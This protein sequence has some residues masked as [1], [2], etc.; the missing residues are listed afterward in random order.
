MIYDTNAL[1]SPED[2]DE[3]RKAKLSYVT[4]LQELL[5]NIQLVKTGFCHVYI[6]DMV[7]P[8]YE[9]YNR[10]LWSLKQMSDEEKKA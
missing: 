2:D 4:M 6:K 7:Q 3:T 1:A 5:F 9:Q 8:E 10:L